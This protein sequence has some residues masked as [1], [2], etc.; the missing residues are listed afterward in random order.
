MTLTL[1][2]RVALALTAGAFLAAAAA[3][4]VLLAAPSPAGG[5]ALTSVTPLASA[6]ASVQPS[7]AGEELVVDVQGGVVNPG[8]VVLPA[9]ARVADAVAAAGGFSDEADTLAAASA[10]NLAAPLTDGSQVYVPLIGVAAGG[11][12]GSGGGNGG[13]SGGLVNL[14]TATPEELDALPGI[15]PVTVQRI[16]AARA[17]R[18]FATLEELVTRDVMHNGQLEEIRDLVTL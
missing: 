16:V 11:P 4:W 9:G 7:R 17:E 13:A 14:N 8:V 6:P 3:A 1:R 2:D 10:L 5:V 18:P 15:G 12:P